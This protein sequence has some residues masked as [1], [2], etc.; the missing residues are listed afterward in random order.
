[1]DINWNLRGPLQLKCM[2]PEN[3]GYAQ[4]T[5]DSGATIDIYE[6][7][8]AQWWSLYCVLPKAPGFTVYRIKQPSLDD[9]RGQHDYLSGFINPPKRE[10]A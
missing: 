10:A 1:M 3:N 8:P 4:L 9:S 7:K 2:F 6:L 5:D